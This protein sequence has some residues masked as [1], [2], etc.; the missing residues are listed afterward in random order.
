[1]TEKADLYNSAYGNYGAEV[2]RQI[3]VETY[4]E[5]LGQTSWVTTEE[6]SEIP[7]LLKL[8]AVSNVLE[9]GSG[10]G[11]YA[12]QVVATTGCRV[13]GVD[14]N[15]PGIQN[16]N[17][18]AAG[19]NLA[20]RVRFEKCDASQPLKFADATFDA[21]FSNDVLCHIPGRG[22]LLR[23]LHRVLEPGGKLLFSDALV[24]GGVISHQEIAARSSIGYFLFSPPGENERLLREAGFAVTD[25]KDTT[26][27]ASLISQRWRE[28]RQK[29]A[30][31]SIAIEGKE[32]FEA[33]QR[34][35]STV[36]T[37]TSERRLLR[38]L[39]LATKDS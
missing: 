11:R 37:L 22:K 14:I 5:D 31:T 21:V 23:E 20:E 7:R 2:Y 8:T 38:L 30:E 32:N 29:R 12:L 16:A 35:L 39:Y 24:I 26:A 33:L 17:A 18:L 13:L 4:G 15:E 25:V 19:Q 34:F 28:A 10:S 27:N 6:S 36:H 3:R 9:I 1:M